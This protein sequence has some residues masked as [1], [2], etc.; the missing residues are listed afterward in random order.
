MKV[1][2]APLASP[3]FVFPMVA[4]ADRLRALGHSCSFVTNVT[5]EEFLSSRG[6]VRI[7]R[8]A[9]EGESFEVNGWGDPLRVVMQLRHIEHALR[10]FQP[11]IVLASHL[12]MG[13]LVAKARH[14][15]PVAMLG[16]LVHLYP[17]QTS[18]AAPGSRERAWRHDEM[19]RC[20]NT[21]LAALQMP[22]AA[23]TSLDESPVLGTHYFIQG[24]AEMHASSLPMPTRTSFVGSC[25]LDAGED[26]CDDEAR[27]WMDR[28]AD[29]RRP[30][31]Y[32]RLGRSSRRR[33]T[34]LRS[35]HPWRRATSPRW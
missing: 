19:L 26:F 17:T 31:L 2:L 5:Y 16:S 33:R 35:P 21:A 27:A 24:V 4:I 3:G 11:D 8:G 29:A 32:V 9:R 23:E 28:Q 25:L 20:L 13:P 10:V 30:L 7:P 1:L 12:A 14:G 22:P 6:Y 15:V 18:L 34:G